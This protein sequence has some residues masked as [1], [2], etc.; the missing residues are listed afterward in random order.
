MLCPQNDCSRAAP[1]TLGENFGPWES[2]TIDGVGTH[3]SICQCVKSAKWSLRVSVGI[4]LTEDG[5]MFPCYYDTLRLASSSC[6]CE[7]TRTSLTIYG[8]I[9][10]RPIFCV[11]VAPSRAISDVVTGHSGSL[12]VLRKTENTPGIP[13]VLRTCENLEIPYLLQICT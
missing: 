12:R 10:P 7:G 9:F 4:S 13:A 6:C 11:L 5:D 8:N 2:S 3:Y 1:I